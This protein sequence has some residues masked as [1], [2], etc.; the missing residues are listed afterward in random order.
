VHGLS[1]L[2][3]ECIPGSAKC[4]LEFGKWKNTQLYFLEEDFGINKVKMSQIE[5]NN[6]NRR[7]Y[8]GEK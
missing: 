3:L 8:N 2:V 5:E 4:K 7:E 6:I 1:T